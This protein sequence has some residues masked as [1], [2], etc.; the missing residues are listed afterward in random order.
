MQAE[1]PKAD[2]EGDCRVGFAAQSR[3]QDTFDARTDV[4]YIKGLSGRILEFSGD[5]VNALVI[6]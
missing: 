1:D 6:N 2:Q 5:V 3:P 4:F